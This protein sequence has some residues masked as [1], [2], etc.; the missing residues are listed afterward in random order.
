MK[1][2]T[3]CSNGKSDKCIEAKIDLAIAETDKNTSEIK[4]QS[5]LISSTCI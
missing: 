3:S 2:I 5:A 4:K 1:N